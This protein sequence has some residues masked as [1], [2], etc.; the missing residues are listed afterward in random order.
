M[1]WGLLPELPLQL[2]VQHPGMLQLNAPGIWP[3]ASTPG[4]FPRLPTPCHPLRD[5]AMGNEPRG[6]SEGRQEKRGDDWDSGKR[7]GVPE[8]CGSLAP[9]HQLWSGKA[10][11]RAWVTLVR[12]GWHLLLFLPELCLSACPYVGSLAALGTRGA[13]CLRSDGEWLHSCGELALSF[14]LRCWLC[15]PVSH[16]T[17]FH[18]KPALAM[19]L[20]PTKCHWGTLL[21]LPDLAVITYWPLWDAWNE[22]SSLPCFT[23]S[24]CSKSQ[25]CSHA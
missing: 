12:H 13:V 22:Q 25:S 15:F 14:I 8:G 18:H 6:P 4:T 3:G 24:C 11:H 5:I 7:K 2:W 23:E 20:C 19:A 21:Q 10:S 9:Q 1:W 17:S 16:V